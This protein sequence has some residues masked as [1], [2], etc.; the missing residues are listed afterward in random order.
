MAVNEENNPTP[1]SPSSS[2]EEVDSNIDFAETDVNKAN[3]KC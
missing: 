2:P 3:S 1:P